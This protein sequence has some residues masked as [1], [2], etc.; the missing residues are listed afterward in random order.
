MEDLRQ[1]FIA[2]SKSEVR[3][4]KQ[5]LRAF[6]AHKPNKALQM[7]EWMEKDTYI[8]REELA[9]RLYGDAKSRAFL[10]L[11]RRLMEKMLETLSLC[12]GFSFAYTQSIP[13]DYF[14]EMQVCRYLQQVCLLRTLGLEELAQEMLEKGRKKAEEWDLPHAKLQTVLMEPISNARAN[15]LEAQLK[16]NLSRNSHE[17]QH[18]PTWKNFLWIDKGDMEEIHQFGPHFSSQITAAESPS[19]YSFR[20]QMQL[21]HQKMKQ[22]VFTR[23]F[24]DAWNL[25]ERDDGK[26]EYCWQCRFQWILGN[27]LYSVGRAGNQPKPLATRV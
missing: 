18:T 26:F 5:F 13:P 6:Q 4:L 2:M 25:L 12:M 11:K 22:A 15:L 19:A 27:G 21:L 14:H 17:S 3:F 24:P 9:L 1:V 20:T 7:V 16:E 23:S 8:S 10:M